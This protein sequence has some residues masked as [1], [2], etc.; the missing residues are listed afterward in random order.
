MRITSL[1]D[2]QGSVY[3][4]NV[5]LIRGDWNAI[6]DTNTLV[7]VGNDV[8]VIER[9]RAISTGVGKK[10]VDQV[11][12]TH[13]HFDHVGVL[14]AIRDAFD[15]IVY[16]HSAFVGADKSL[17]DWQKLRCGDRQFEVVYTPG[18]SHDS[19]CL[20]CHE[21]GVLFAGDSPLVIRS[22]GGS[23]DEDFRRAL[24]RLGKKDVRTIYPGHGPPITA[25]GPEWLRATIENVRNACARQAAHAQG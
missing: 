12:L 25:R 7:D 13:G 18:H 23:Y 1:T 3:T 19:V 4:S 5:Y 6:G 24:E 9:V 2:T 8:K 16:A 14:S 17:G 15:P 21:D 10:A 11:I 20:Y 22:D